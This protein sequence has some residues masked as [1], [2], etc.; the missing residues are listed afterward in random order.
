MS[1]V[2]PLNKTVTLARL[3]AR[4]SDGRQV[5]DGADA[6][7]REDKRRIA[8]EFVLQILRFLKRGNVEQSHANEPA[9]GPISVRGSSRQ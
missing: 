5:F 3:T 1:P 6:V 2:R 9:A 8:R 7:S 4:Q